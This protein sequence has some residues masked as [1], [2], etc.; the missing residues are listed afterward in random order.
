LKPESKKNYFRP[1]IATKSA[2][3]LI[4][5]ILI[6]ILLIAFVSSHLC[7]SK[8]D[9]SK[10]FCSTFLGSTNIFKPLYLRSEPKD[11]IKLPDSMSKGLTYFSS[12]LIVFV[13]SDVVAMSTSLLQ[14]EKQ[15]IMTSI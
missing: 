4:I 7:D 10:D 8:V 14:T 11:N 12:L 15:Q 2:Q 13:S 3:Q 1:Q 6:P 9:E 5:F